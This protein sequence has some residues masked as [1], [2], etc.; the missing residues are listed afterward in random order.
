M[1]NP[2]HIKKI[3]KKTVPTIK[4]KFINTYKCNEIIFTYEMKFEIATL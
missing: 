1:N 4:N 2:H 3:N